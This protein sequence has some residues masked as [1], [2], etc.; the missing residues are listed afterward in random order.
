M[1]DKIG[2]FNSFIITNI[3]ASFSSLFIWTF[4]K[5]YGPLLCYA[6]LFGFSSTTYYFLLSP[7]V[8][9]LVPEDQ[10]YSGLTL[11]LVTN[12]FPLFGP[13]I[14]SVI[15][16]RVNTAPFF[17]HIIFTGVSYLFGAVLLF[18]VKLGINKHP[19]AKV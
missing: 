2:Y 15:Q 6:I 13:N 14:S 10:F 18:G 1:A 19:F 8:T 16:E 9:T 7:I 3:I 5:T 17:T 4:A 12:C 11:A